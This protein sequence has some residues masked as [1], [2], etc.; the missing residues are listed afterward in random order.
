MTGSNLDY[1]ETTAN[2]DDKAVE[3]TEADT[4]LR[5]IVERAVDMMR[6]AGLNYDSISVEVGATLGE[7]RIS[8]ANWEG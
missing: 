1:L 6:F 7:I 8:F 4:D 3:E 2:L 5:G